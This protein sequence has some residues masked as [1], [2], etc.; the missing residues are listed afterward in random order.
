VT[1]HHETAAEAHAAKADVGESRRLPR[2]DRGRDRETPI[3]LVDVGTEEAAD[4]EPGPTAEHGAGEGQH[5]PRVE[6]PAPTPDPVRWNRELEAGD[7]AAWAHDPGQLGD[8]CRR[9]RDVAKQVREREGVERGV[10]KRQPLTL[11]EYQGDPVVQTS[12]RHVAATFAQH[13]LAQVEAGDLGGQARRQF[14]RDAGRAGG[15]IEHGGRRGRDHVVDHLA[16]PSTVLAEGQHR[17]QAVVPRG[18]AGEQPASEAGRRATNDADVHGPPVRWEHSAHDLFPRDPMTKPVVDAVVVGAGPAGSTAALLLARSGARVM[19][20]DKATF[21]RDKACGDLVGPRAV[22]LITSLGLEVPAG[23]PVGEMV[24]VGPTG[25]RVVL[26]ARAGRTY[27]DHGVAISRRRFDDWLRSA[28]IAAGAEAVTGRVATVRDG[29]V[30]LDD[31]RCVATDVV[32]GADGATSGIA[33][34]TGLV[35]PHAVLWGFACRAYVIQHVERPVIAL[36]DEAPGRGFPGYGWIF[37]GEGDHANIG[38]GIG[39][40]A[41]RANASRAVARFDAF[42]DHLRCCGLL[43]A[44]VDGQRLGG[45]LKMGMVGTVAARGRVFLVGDA[46]GLVNPLQGEGIA[47]AMASAAAAAAAII[48][49]PGTAAARYRRELAAGPGRYAMATAP[50]HAAAISGSARR[51]AR[52]SRILTSP[53]I[54]AS[55]A[56]PWALLWNDLLDGAPRGATTR[57]A[58]MALAFGRVAGSRTDV[59]RQLKRDL[60][61]T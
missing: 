47:P 38:L 59:Q 41:D 57:A 37:P 8:C 58:T 32:I 11:A 9:I 21:P 18:K 17:G 60:H 5:D 46:A 49:S 23:R 30:E 33:A 40:R 25:R 28:A 55:I 1:P 26:P 39:L 45:W 29:I 61:D 36:W 16:S 14:E 24:V 43:C 4:V 10:G 13:V 50:I 51:V 15:D 22:A 56:P 48:A 27:P 44:T 7:N 54:G 35:D 2:R 42:C 12:S 19:L 20:I 52:L 3:V 31:G 34:A 6:T 53:F